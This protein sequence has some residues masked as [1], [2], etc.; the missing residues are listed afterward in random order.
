MEQL[1]GKGLNKTF[2]T[3]LA[4]LHIFNGWTD[5][6]LTAPATGLRRVYGLLN[7]EI[8]GVKLTGI[9]QEYT[10][11]TGK[12]DYGKEWGFLVTK[13]FFKH[14]NVLAKYS[15]YDASANSGKFDA[16]RFWLSAGISF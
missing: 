6:F 1:D 16:Q 7:T 11:D 9:Y 13:E 15:Y 8:E 10:D 2:D 3:P 14:Y 4:T 5:Q 12:F